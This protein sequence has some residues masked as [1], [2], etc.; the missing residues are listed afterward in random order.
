MV[1]INLIFSRTTDDYSCLDMPSPPTYALRQV[2]KVIDRLL[3]EY[4]EKCVR[5]LQILCQRIPHV[6]ESCQIFRMFQLRKGQISM[7]SLV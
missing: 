7:S 5:Y 3:E 4:I 6:L 2:S 1:V